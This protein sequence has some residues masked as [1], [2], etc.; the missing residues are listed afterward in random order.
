VDVVQRNK[1]SIMN[2][3]TLFNLYN[4][5]TKYMG[6]PHSLFLLLIRLYWGWLF[7]QAGFGKFTHIERTAQFFGSLG[8]PSPEIMAYFIAS[9][10]TFGGILL[11]LGFA[12][13]LTGLVLAGN[14]IGAFLVAHR[15]ALFHIVSKPDDFY[16]ALPFSFLFASLVI[17]FCGG[18]MFSVDYLIKKFL[19]N[20]YKNK[21]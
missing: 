20:R 15:E 13:R 7:F 16:M 6:I 17:L 14:M 5:I 4:K 1:E 9:V 3:E 2:A 18:G 19:I 10:E 21:F 12:S 11:I 8:L